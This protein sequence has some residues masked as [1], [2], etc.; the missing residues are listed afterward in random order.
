MAFED[1]VEPDFFES[2]SGIL[3]ATEMKLVPYEG[4][5]GC[6]ATTCKEFGDC[7]VNIWEYGLVCATA[8]R[9]GPCRN[10]RGAP[11]MCEGVFAGVLTNPQR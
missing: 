7:L 10:D 3:Q 11:L 5:S 8:K 2:S 4:D 9:G 1:K 6:L